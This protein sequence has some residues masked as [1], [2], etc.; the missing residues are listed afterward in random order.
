MKRII[1]A[2]TA[3]VIGLGMVGPANASA[4]A[5][6]PSAAATDYNRGGYEISYSGATASRMNCASV[7]YAMG[8]FRSKVRRQSGYPRIP[9]S[10]FDGWVTWS[11]WKT[12]TH[13]VKCWE[14]QSGTS[15]RFRA[16]IW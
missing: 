10:F 2:V 8:R 9:G 14:P 13:G 4:S 7:N 6:C 3:A 16:Y 5:Y 15:Y 1:T 11:C 12:S